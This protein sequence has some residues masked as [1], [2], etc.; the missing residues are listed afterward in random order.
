M[1]HD[2]VWVLWWK[3]S[4]GSRQGVLRVYEDETRANEDFDLVDESTDRTYFLDPIPF[5]KTSLDNYLR[6]TPKKEVNKSC[7]N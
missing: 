4:D 3:Y 1:E 2:T 5:F 7:Q 6:N